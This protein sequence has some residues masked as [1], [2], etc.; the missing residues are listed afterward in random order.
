MGPLS[1]VVG[2][3]LS[4][5]GFIGGSDVAE[6]QAAE[7]KAIAADQLKLEAQK[8]QAMELDANRRQLEV[9]RNLQRARSLG[10]VNAT[11]QG[12]GS[13]SGLHGGYGQAAGE[14]N[15]NMLGINQAL[16]IGRTMFDINADMSQ[17]KMAL[18]DL[19]ADAS[20][21]SG[22]G[23]LGNSLMGASGSIGKLASGGE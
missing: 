21:Y 12:A 5:A 19:G 16:Q 1:F 8:K 6:K 2:A 3:G 23:S 20:F 15:T 7:Q 14:A 17:H 11:A 9:F 10:L 4:I 22:L 13:S 18:A